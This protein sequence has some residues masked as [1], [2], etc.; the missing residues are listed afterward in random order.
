MTCLETHKSVSLIVQLLSVWKLLRM[1]I[2][3]GRGRARD[4]SLMRL[5]L[6]Y[7]CQLGLSVLAPRT[8]HVCK[9]YCRRDLSL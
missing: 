2:R 7:T 5:L 9:K 8:H 3:L 6:I 4:Y 1:R